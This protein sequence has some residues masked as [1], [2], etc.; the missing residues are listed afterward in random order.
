MHC[1]EHTRE[2]FHTLLID[3][4]VDHVSPTDAHAQI[5]GRLWRCSDML[6]G[7]DRE[8]LD[9]PRGSSYAQAARQVTQDMP[10]LRS[11]GEQC[12]T[13]TPGSVMERFCRHAN[14]W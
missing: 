12:L 7:D 13:K 1:S 10:R 11:H 6:P 4:Y 9:M 8:I 2:Q 5:A 14:V 3:L